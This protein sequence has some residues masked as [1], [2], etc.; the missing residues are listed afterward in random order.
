[1]LLLL[2]VKPFSYLLKQTMVKCFHFC[3]SAG[4]VVI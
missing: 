4:K 1:M 2:K 3:K